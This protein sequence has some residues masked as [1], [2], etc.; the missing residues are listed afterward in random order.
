MPPTNSKNKKTD[1]SLPQPSPLA[2]KA[3]F[4]FDLDP[5]SQK[6]LSPEIQ[7]F[8]SAIVSA[9]TVSFN[10]SVDRIVQAIEG[11]LNQKIDFH[12][13]EIFDLNKRCEKLE[14]D[15]R[16]LTKEI[17]ILKDQSRNNHNKFE[18][19]LQHTDDLEQ[20]S[21]GAN[22]LIHGLP[23]STQGSQETDLNSK[24]KDF[25]NQNLGITVADSD[26]NTVHRLARNIGT[27]TG[28][29][30]TKPPP[31]LLQFTNR[32]I[33]TQVLAKRKLLKGKNVLITEHLTAKKSQL[34]KKASELVTQRKLLS[35]WSHDGKIL[36]KTLENRTITISL[37]NIDQLV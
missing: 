25:L 28:S 31:I 7:G 26:I 30:T 15:N 10:A 17:S 36:G 6:I 34:L 1:T 9:F 8:M 33:R 35:A 12:A 16:N 3:S 2:A 37:S 24:M 23:V 4:D 13:V 14:E 32:S 22:I 29:N 27:N 5:N 20:Y 19:I 18:T 21:K 11:K